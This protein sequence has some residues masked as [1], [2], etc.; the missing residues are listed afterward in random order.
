MADSLEK[1]IFERI[2]LREKRFILIWNQSSWG[3][4]PELVEPMVFSNELQW[5][6]KMTGYLLSGTNNDDQSFMQT[7][8]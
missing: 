3:I 7:A 1:N 8:S 2:Y 6:D 5:L 4:R